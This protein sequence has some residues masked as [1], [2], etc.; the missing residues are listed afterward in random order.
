MC[1]MYLVTTGEFHAL[2]EIKVSLLLHDEVP[3]CVFII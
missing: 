1:T 2:D 3:W